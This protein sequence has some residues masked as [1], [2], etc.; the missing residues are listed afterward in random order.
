MI[1]RIECPWL[2]SLSG[3][4]QGL[5]AVGVAREVFALSLL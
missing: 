4:R 2:A 3:A 1:S 5:F